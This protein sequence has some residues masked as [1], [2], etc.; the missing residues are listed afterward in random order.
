M[1]NSKKNKNFHIFMAEKLGVNVRSTNKAARAQKIDLRRE[2]R[3]WI[4]QKVW[5][6][7][8][9]LK[10]VQSAALLPQDPWKLSHDRLSAT[11]GFSSSYL[12]KYSSNCDAWP[13]GWKQL[14]S[15][16]ITASCGFDGFTPYATWCLHNVLYRTCVVLR[17]VSD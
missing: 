10:L 6:T 11:L 9:P 3:R 5:L 17:R 8:L 14:I 1:K 2:R 15:H 4:K 7:G 13:L 16:V 12:S